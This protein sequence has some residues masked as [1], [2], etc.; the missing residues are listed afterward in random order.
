LIEK[1]SAKT[2]KS[3]SISQAHW[4][5]VAEWIGSVVGGK[6]EVAFH[7]VRFADEAVEALWHSIGVEYGDQPC[8]QG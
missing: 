1:S 8:I 3:K 7:E 4:D 2:P 6:I 5:N